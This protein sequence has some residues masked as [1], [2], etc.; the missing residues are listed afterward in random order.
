MIKISFPHPLWKDEGYSPLAAGSLWTDS[1]EQIDKSRFSKMQNQADPSLIITPPEGVNPSDNEIERIMLKMAAWH[2]GPANQGKLMAAPGGSTVDQFG[3]SPKDMDWGTGFEQLRNAIMGMH[4][5]P[6]IAAGITDGGSYA[7]FY[8]ALKQFIA[9]CVQPRLDWI[10]E[11]LS[12]QL[13][14]QYGDGLMVRLIAQ[15]VDDPQVLEARLQTDIAGRWIKKNEGRALRGMAPVE[16]GDVWA[17]ES[18]KESIKADASTDPGLAA[19][20]A[21]ASNGSDDE[22]TGISTGQEKPRS[23]ASHFEGARQA[24][25]P[26]IGAAKHS[27]GFNR[28]AKAASL[29]WNGQSE[30]EDYP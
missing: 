8:A 15:S 12:Y 9:L 1:S 20:I 14:E 24:G 22:S 21:G 29:L 30:G 13:A 16:D 4:G 11:E 7:A 18:L 2:T 10:A 26:T 27:P 5:V 25:N 3:T 28:L 19:Q 6:L 17:G 23:P